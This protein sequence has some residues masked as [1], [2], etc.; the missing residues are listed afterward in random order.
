MP[1]PLIQQW[2]REEV[3]GIVSAWRFDSLVRPPCIGSSEM[4]QR[5]MLPSALWITMGHF[6]W[7]NN[8]IWVRS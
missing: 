6:L 5:G 3:T 2:P 7:T 4:K 1:S 8:K